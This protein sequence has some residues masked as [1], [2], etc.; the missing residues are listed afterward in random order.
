MKLPQVPSFQHL[1]PVSLL[2][3][4]Y[5]IICQICNIAHILM[6]GSLACIELLIWSE[7]CQIFMCCIHD[8][9]FFTLH[10]WVI[11][12]FSLLIAFAI[13]ILQWMHFQDGHI[14]YCR[15]SHTASHTPVH[16]CCCRCCCYYYSIVLVYLLIA[17]SCV[18]DRYTTEVNWYTESILHE[19]V[20]PLCFLQ[21][22]KMSSL[23]MQGQTMPEH[24]GRRAHRKSLH[25]FSILLAFYPELSGKYDS[26]FLHS[27]SIKQGFM[28]WWCTSVGLEASL[29]E[30]NTCGVIFSVFFI[31]VTIKIIATGQ[32]L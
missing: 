28:P 20:V 24:A 11:V 22:A 15:S 18:S 16:I 30:R 21:M 12:T 4:N 6:P 26:T 3:S 25:L 8:T 19:F 13:S 14:R 5:Y 7:E 27:G 23:Y 10:S 9:R 2:T 31:I 1:V 32:Y 17:S 29:S